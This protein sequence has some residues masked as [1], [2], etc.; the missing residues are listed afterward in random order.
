[1]R[2]RPLVM[3]ASAITTGVILGWLALLFVSN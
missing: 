1:M 2:D 3:I